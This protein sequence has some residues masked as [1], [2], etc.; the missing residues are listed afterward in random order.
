MSVSHSA[1]YEPTRVDVWTVL[2]EL[3]HRVEALLKRHKCPRELGFEAFERE[4]HA[5]FTHAECAAT[6]EAL[7]R[8][9]VDLPHVFLDGEKHHRAYRGEKTY[10]CAVGPVTAMRTLYRT[11]TGER[12]VAAMERRGASW[13]GTG[14]RWR[15]ARA[16][17]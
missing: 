11:R 8:H 7:E 4:L 5:L 13:R 12:A 17:C 2:E 1:Q 9:D 10:L 3:P 15:R 16:R 6:A 14:R